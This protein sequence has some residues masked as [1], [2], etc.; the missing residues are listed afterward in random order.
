MHDGGARTG[1][2]GVTGGDARRKAGRGRFEGGGLAVSKEDPAKRRVLGLIAESA[3]GEEGTC[4]GD[5][6][7]DLCDP[8]EGVVNTTGYV[9]RDGDGDVAGVRTGDVLYLEDESWRDRG[10][11]RCAGGEDVR[12]GL[13]RRAC[14]IPAGVRRRVGV[15]GETLREGLLAGEEDRAGWS[16][17]RRTEERKKPSAWSHSRTESATGAVGAELGV[18][19][20]T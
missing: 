12:D 2:L 15:D 17:T 9:S 4:E 18:D 19:G 10:E 16:W 8:G 13:V 20:V 11:V 6:G 7:L 1:G 5:E 3:P 14:R